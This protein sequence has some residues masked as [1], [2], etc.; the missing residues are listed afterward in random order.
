MN[1]SVLT[2][3]SINALIVLALLVVGTIVV[4]IIIAIVDKQDKRTREHIVIGQRL[5]KH[6]EDEYA[7][8]KLN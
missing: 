7:K 2:Q 4:S 8:S 5:A 6:Y 1:E 3:T